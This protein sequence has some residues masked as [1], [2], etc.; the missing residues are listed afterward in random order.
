MKN[1]VEL[2]VGLFMIA[3]FAAFG[4]LALQ[5]REKFLYSVRVRIIR[6]LLNL[7]ILQV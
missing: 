6:L 4:Y 2:I 5:F 3:G 1:G 7:I